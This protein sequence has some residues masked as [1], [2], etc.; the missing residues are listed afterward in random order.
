MPLT[1]YLSV[2]STADYIGAISKGLGVGAGGRV[3]SVTYR[4]RLYLTP[5]G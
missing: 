1:D 3:G 5:Q 2:F 4:D